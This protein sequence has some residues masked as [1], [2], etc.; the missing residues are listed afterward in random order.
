MKDESRRS[1]GICRP[2]RLREAEEAK[3]METPEELPILPIGSRSCFQNAPAAHGQPGTV[4]QAHRCRPAGNKMIGIVPI[5]TR[6]RPK[7]N[8]KTCSKWDFGLHPED[9]QDANDSIRLL[10]QGISASASALYPAGPF[11]RPG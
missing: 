8:R 1:W 9:A 7:S 11:L 5:K 6:R 4:D 10:I 3:G 2:T